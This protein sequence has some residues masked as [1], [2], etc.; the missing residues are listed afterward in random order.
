V[1]RHRA[2]LTLLA[3]VS[4][5]SLQPAGAGVQ[6]PTRG[7]HLLARDRRPPKGAATVGVVRACDNFARMDQ[8]SNA[9]LA[10]RTPG[11]SLSGLLPY[12][13]AVS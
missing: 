3:A 6:L 12:S 10:E 8:L 4:T 11:P 13:A 2:S 9:K 1:T 5:G 7:S